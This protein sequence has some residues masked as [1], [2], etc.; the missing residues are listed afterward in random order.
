MT[1]SDTAAQAAIGAAARELHLPTVRAEATRLAEIA[2]RE[3]QT[4]LA[5]LAEVLS[6]EV[7]D[8]TERRRT[9]RIA[10]AKFPRLKRL[11]EFNVDAVPTIQPATLA[12]LATGNYMDAGEPIVLL[13]DSGTGKSHLL[14]ALGFAACEQGRRVR[15]VTTAQLVNELVEAADER[16][17]SRAAPSCC[18][19]SSPNARNES[20]PAPSPTSYAPPRRRHGANARADLSTWLPLPRQPAFC[21]PRD[22]RGD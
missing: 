4:H 1:V 3:R 14:I 18:S 17:L 7:D 5:F 20:R 19:R 11:A 2:V 13:G 6:A 22:E 9:R 12:A 10:E 21:A 15:Y 8:R 16:Q